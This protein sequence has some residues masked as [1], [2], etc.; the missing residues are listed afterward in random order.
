MRFALL[1]TSLVGA[2]A[3]LGCDEAS[4]MARCKPSFY[5]TS[6]QDNHM[7]HE[8]NQGT[9]VRL[10]AIG[11]GQGRRTVVIC[12]CPTHVRTPDAESPNEHVGDMPSMRSP[13]WWPSASM[14]DAG[15][16]PD[17]RRATWR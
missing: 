15:S 13:I 6:P 5:I 17:L 1:L 11:D 12:D 8:C 14:P 2:L 9:H 7:L 16:T 4:Q 10:D 3:A